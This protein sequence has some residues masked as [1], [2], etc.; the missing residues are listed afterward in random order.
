MSYGPRPLLAA[1]LVTPFALACGPGPEEVCGLP[2]A[3]P[4]AE[5]VADNQVVAKLNG[6]GFDEP[7]S[8]SAGPN[9]SLTAGT[10]NVVIARDN[11]G[12]LTSDLVGRGAFPICVDIG[13]RS[14][15]S[16]NADFDG[17]FLSDGAHTGSV[18]ILGEEEGLLTGR[19]RLELKDN[20]G[21][22]AP[23][24]FEDGM[25]RIPRR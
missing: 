1:L 14:D 11:T 19:F 21:A 20:L 3:K 6:G 8:W 12:T 15:V 17:H 13:E 22:D 25:F 2:S 16:G 5:D 23:A 7:G 9:G 4:T 18:A 24:V 10:L